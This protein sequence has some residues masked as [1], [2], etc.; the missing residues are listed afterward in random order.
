MEEFIK[1]LLTTVEDNKKKEALIKINE[2][3]E[4]IDKNQDKI[5]YEVSVCAIPT[6]IRIINKGLIKEKYSPKKLIEKLEEYS[7]LKGNKDGD[8][9][10]CLKTENYFTNSISEEGFKIK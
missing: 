10:M 2:L 7:Y 6:L 3:I 1:E 4:Y 5:N 8:E 9:Q